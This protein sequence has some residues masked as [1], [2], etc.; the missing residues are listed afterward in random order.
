MQETQQMTDAACLERL[1]RFTR[2]VHTGDEVY[3]F[4][5]KLCDNEIDRDGER[6]SREALAQLEK[7]FVGK[8]GIFDHNPTGENQT[9]RIFE[10][11]LVE[12]P[13]RQTTAGEVY[14]YLKGYAYMIRTEKN[15]DLIREIEGGIKK[16]V[17]IS[18]AAAAQTCSI[19]GADRNK[20]GCVHQNGHVY[21]GKVCHTVLSDITDAYEWSFVAV[22]A[23]REAGVTKR[24]GEGT[25][26]H[27][28]K[29]IER[30]LQEKEQL[31][32]RVEKQV[33]ADIVRLRFLT[34]GIDEPDAAAAVFE[35]MTLA[36]LLAFQETL[37]TK[38]RGECERQLSNR[39]KPN[40]MQN[41]AFRME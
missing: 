8:T 24:F 36:E 4:E 40:G 5:V 7:L 2:R 6:F 10:T 25:E 17:S 28:M 19:C 35:R 29:A 26:H 9:A 15:R 37:R 38:Q 39:G 1:N 12:E 30:Q 41:Q 16:E 20:A 22:P 31:L 18:C 33:R 14:T 27:R 11:S 32:A 3:W 21:G 34:E 23:Q 13:E